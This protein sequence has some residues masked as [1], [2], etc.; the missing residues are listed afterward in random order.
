MA[1]HKKTEMKSW[2]QA[3]LSPLH[4]QQRHAQQH[5]HP[6]HHRPAA[7]SAAPGAA[8]AGAAAPLPAASPI[9]PLLSGLRARYAAL[10][11]R[12]RGLQRA[13]EELINWRA[14]GYTE[15]YQLDFRVRRTL[16][17]RG[18]VTALGWSGDGFSLATATAD[19]RVVLWN[20][21]MER[22]RAVVTLPHEW[23]LAL[24]L[25]PARDELLAVGGLSCSV[26][27]FTQAELL[28][29]GGEGARPSAVL[30][31]ARS[32]ALGA[33][34][35]TSYISA[36]RFPTP[37]RVATASG[38]GSLGVWDLTLNHRLHTLLPGGAAGP[39]GC[40]TCHPM[41][42]DMLVAGSADGFLRVWD[43]RLPPA[44]A[45]ALLLGGFHGAVNACDF[46]PSGMAV[47]GAGED[48]T[49]RLF[50]L[51]SAGAVGIYTEEALGFA[52]TGCAF[53]R[54][55]ALVFA[56][57]AGDGKC[58]VWEPLSADGVLHELKGHAGT[59]S[60]LAVNSEGQAIATG[61]YDSKVLV[62]A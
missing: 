38:D 31:G 42:P 1:H 17:G 50:D 40:L 16:R 26:T 54:S 48:S 58:C 49:V 37:D 28:R 30:G 56:S 52:A 20:A 25:E 57:Y 14:S 5:R 46:F 44:A 4:Q 24:A 32:S 62:W 59:V 41:D 7:A 36:V 35:H 15:G 55:G 8:P 29:R 60:C 45:C 22:M 12:L 2:E 18:R 61:G 43:L 9:P 19:G 47:A 11:T 51:R 53:S 3:V 34:G 27:I 21:N 23:P 6:P 33:G 10:L 13:K 39:A